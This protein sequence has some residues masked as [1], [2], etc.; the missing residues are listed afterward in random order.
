[1]PAAP[2]NRRLPQI[3]HAIR[4]LERKTIQNV[5]E[6]GKLLCEASEQCA[7]GEYMPWLKREFGWSHDTSLNFRNVYVLSQIPKFSDFA[8]LNMNISISALYMAARFL[9]DDQPSDVQAAGEAIIAAARHQR[10]SYTM[11]CDIADEHLNPDVERVVDTPVDHDD[12]GADEHDDLPRASLTPAEPLAEDDDDLES[13]DDTE[14][15]AIIDKD[16]KM[17]R[18]G[19]H[20]DAE[21]DDDAE[22]VSEPRNADELNLILRK[23]YAAR[24]QVM[25]DTPQDDPFWLEFF[26]LVGTAKLRELIAKLQAIHNKHCKESN[27]KAAADRAETKAKGLH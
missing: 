20:V 4:A 9:R 14:I 16:G 21:P 11:A 15:A 7:H 3:A 22:T 13:D 26:R 5:I 24:L 8:T 27:V 19:P 2:T 17:W 6:I 1:M 18:I 10:V 12:G 23:R 25:L